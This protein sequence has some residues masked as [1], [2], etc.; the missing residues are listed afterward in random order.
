MTGIGF[1][2]AEKFSLLQSNKPIDMVYTIDENEWN[3]EKNLQLM[4]IDIRLSEC[5]TA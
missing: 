1:N 3:G 4:V 2:M 5:A